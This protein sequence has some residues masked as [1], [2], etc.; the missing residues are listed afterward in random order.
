MLLLHKG[1]VSEAWLEAIRIGC[2]GKCEF[3]DGGNAQ[4]GTDRDDIRL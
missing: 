4:K 1:I 2:G 3:V